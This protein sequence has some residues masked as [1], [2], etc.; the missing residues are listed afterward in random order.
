MNNRIKKNSLLS[1]ITLMVFLFSYILIDSFYYRV[2]ET[3]GSYNQFNSLKEMEEVSDLIVKV[4]VTEDI[5][6]QMILHDGLPLNYWTETTVV[7]QKVFH[8][9][10]QLKPGETITVEL[11]N[12]MIRHKEIAPL[13]MFGRTYILPNLAFS[14]SII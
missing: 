14:F 6:N 1:I 12:D 5:Q 10:D 11:F 2:I 4:K 13:V 9:R 3:Q 8:S 7:V